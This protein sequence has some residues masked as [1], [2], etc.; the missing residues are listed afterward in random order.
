MKRFLRL[1]P[2]GITL[3]RVFLS[4]LF[5]ADTIGQ[6]AYGKNNLIRLAA[7]FLLICLTD[8]VDGRFARRLR[9]A[10]A[11]GARLDVLADLFFLA[12][13]NITLAWLGLLPPWFCGF[14]LL[15]FIEFTVTSKYVLR[16]SCPEDGHVFVFD[17]VGRVVSALFFVVPGAVCVLH[18][19]APGIADGLIYFLL[20]T[21]LAG[22]VLSSY[23][24]VRSCVRLLA[25]NG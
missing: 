9:C 23:F 20:Y 21:L 13:S 3:L 22:G 17:K 4:I 16:H 2:N 10:S 24:R 14:L 8:F 11:A 7:V 5:A 19:L 12:V 15:K 6:F 25:S 18:V 1:I